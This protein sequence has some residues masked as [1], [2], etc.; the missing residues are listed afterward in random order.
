MAMPDP[1]PRVLTVP[2]LLNT[3]EA[4]GGFLCV[5]FKSPGVATFYRYNPGR[6]GFEQIE[7]DTRPRRDDEYDE[8]VITTQ[9]RNYGCFGRQ[10]ARDCLENWMGPSVEGNTVEFVRYDETPFPQQNELPE[11][12]G[13]NYR[14]EEDDAA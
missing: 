2:E 1:D 6:D 13:A 9:T 5:V 3:L 10:Q 12:W 7:C 4:S 14:V 8:L 11:D